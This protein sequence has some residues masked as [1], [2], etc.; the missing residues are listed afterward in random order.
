M[1]LDNSFV[2]KDAWNHESRLK[3]LT[4]T[5]IIVIAVIAHDLISYGYYTIRIT[6]QM[7]ILL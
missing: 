5:F 6:I 3:L 2:F 1:N 4:I 7:L